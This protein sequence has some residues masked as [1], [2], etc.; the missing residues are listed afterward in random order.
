MRR[1]RCVNSDCGVTWWVCGTR[2]RFEADVQRNSGD[3]GWI[4]RSCTCQWDALVV[5]SVH[6]HLHL[7]LWQRILI[8]SSDGGVWNEAGAL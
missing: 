2:S 1:Q 5:R 4:L 8:A 3:R 6:A 7:L